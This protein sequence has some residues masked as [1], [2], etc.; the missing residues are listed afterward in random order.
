MDHIIWTIHYGRFFRDLKLWSGCTIPV[1][2]RENKV[3]KSCSNILEHERI[4]KLEATFSKKYK[5]R[6]Y[7]KVFAMNIIKSLA[8]FNSAEEINWRCKADSDKVLFN[9]QC[10]H[11]YESEVESN[12]EALAHLDWIL[13]PEIILFN[14]LSI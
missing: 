1:Y 14:F 13:H 12:R 5:E 4:S 11:Y 10:Y 2:Y 9:S 8:N 6:Q 3:F 7:V